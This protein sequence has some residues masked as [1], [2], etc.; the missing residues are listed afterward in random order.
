MSEEIACHGQLAN[1][2]G[3]TQMQA[4]QD[5]E[6]TMYFLAHDPVYDNIK[7]FFLQYFTS[8][9]KP[10]NNVIQEDVSVP[11]SDIRGKENKF[12]FSRNGFAIL[13]LQSKMTYEDFED[14]H[15]IEEL[16]CEELAQCLLHYFHAESIQFFDRVVCH[17]LLSLFKNRL[18]NLCRS[19]VDIKT[20]LT[21]I[22][23]HPP[24]SNQ[25]DKFTLVRLFP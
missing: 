9:G 6:A 8:D 16:Y 10:R 17:D 3:G 15:K 12:T 7:P 18:T 25:Q 21:L 13:D 22:L 1:K 5:I 24:H 14:A 4:S 20:T 2:G 11:I 23:R 19:D